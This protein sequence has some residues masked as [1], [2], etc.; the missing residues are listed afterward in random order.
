[1]FITFSSLYS[2][3]GVHVSRFNIPHTDK[4]VHFT[5]YFVACILGVFFLRERTG[6]KMR[7]RKALLIMVLVTVAFGLLIEVLQYSLTAKRTGDVFD[8]IANTVGSFCGAMLTKF[9]FSDKRGLKWEF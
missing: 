1:M 6:G 2:F 7:L 9:Y 5:F 4:L 8:G 3:E